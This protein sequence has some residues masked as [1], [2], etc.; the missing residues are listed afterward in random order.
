MSNRMLARILHRDEERRRSLSQSTICLHCAEKDLKIGEQKRQIKDL[1]DKLKRLQPQSHRPL[2]VHTPSAKESFKESSREEN[3][4][5]TGGAKVG[6]PGSTRKGADKKTADQIIEAKLPETCGD[7]GG[8]VL[9]TGHDL[10]RVQDLTKQQLLEI[11]YEVA[12]G[13]CT[14]CNKPH[15][16]DYRQDLVR[17]ADETSWRTDGKA[18]YAWIF[19]TERTSIFIFGVSRSSA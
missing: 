12:S 18:G 15:K 1:E 3:R 16:G 13:Y 14:G 9:T 8:K 6:H 17:H 7:C 5:K 10:R 2:G 11:V 19:T 4:R